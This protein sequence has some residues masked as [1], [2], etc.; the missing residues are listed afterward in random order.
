M[1]RESTRVKASQG[2]ALAGG[3]AERDAACDGARVRQREQG[4][5]QTEAERSL[6]GWVGR[7]APQWRIRRDCVRGN[8]ERHYVS[9]ARHLLG[10]E[11]DQRSNAVAA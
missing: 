10:R 2:K 11:R 9:S 8:G 6:V 7:T 4:T 5:R 1:K 3:C